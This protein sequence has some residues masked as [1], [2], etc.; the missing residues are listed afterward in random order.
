MA[1]R[2]Q[3]LKRMP[4]NAGMSVLFS[5]LRAQLGRTGSGAFQVSRASIN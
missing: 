3:P 1:E 4:L 2:T 5:Q